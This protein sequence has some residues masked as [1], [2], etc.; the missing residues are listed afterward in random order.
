M[1]A[2]HK[3]RTY[4]AIDFKSFYASV[5]CVERGLDPLT[6]NLVVANEARTEKT[7]CLAVSPSLKAYGIPGR[8]RLFEVNQILRQVRQSTG[9]K[10]DFVIAPP[11]MKLYIDYSTRIYNIYLKY[12]SHEDIH[13]YSIDEVF[14][15]VTEYLP[16]YGLSA[17]AFASRLLQEVYQI[18]RITATAGIGPNLY[19][20]KIAMDIVAK[21]IEP[22]E[23]GSRIAGLDEISYRELLWSHTP[24]TDFWRIGR[25]TERKLAAHGMHTMGD[26]ARMSLL[27]NYC[28]PT[29]YREDY[30]HYGTAMNGEDFLFSLFGV[31]AEL[32][33]DHAWG[34]EPCQMSDIKGY[35]P[36]MNSLSSGQ[37]LSC[38]YTKKKGELIV[39]E[40]VD[41]LA[42]DLVEKNLV[43]DQL[44]LDIAYDHEI[45]K[46]ESGSGVPAYTGPMT[47]DHY[48]RVVPKPAHGSIRFDAHTSSAR[49]LLNAAAALYNQIVSPAL[50]VHRFTVTFGNVVPETQTQEEFCQLDLFTDYE[51]LELEKREMER[52]RKLQKA[53]LSIKGKF[54]KN[55]ILKGMNLEEGGTAMERNKQIGGHNA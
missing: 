19:L 51:K 35:K 4:I 54:G 16:L 39:R 53:M 18:T 32:L 7:I 41:Q 48:G 44:V 24:L 40:M 2:N 21:H 55:A 46:E 3:Q 38:G 17:S 25:G 29:S 45:S 20:A 36:Q 30:I 5:E 8:A 34:I 47:K 9:K 26:V 31:D 13:V 23:N 28:D 49:K 1:T 37:V 12:V 15:D 11:R 42:L 52:E 33:I 14:M 50:L 43:T 22:D 10:V 6:A 27:K